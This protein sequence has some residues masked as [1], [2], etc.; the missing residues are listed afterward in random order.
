MVGVYFVIGKSDSESR[1]CLIVNVVV[2]VITN[3]VT[4]LVAINYSRESDSTS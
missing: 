1:I 4:G 3:T 2:R